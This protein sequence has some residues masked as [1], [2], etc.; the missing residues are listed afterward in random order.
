MVALAGREASNREQATQFD[1][2]RQLAVLLIGGADRGGG[3][4]GDDE[5]EGSMVTHGV[6]G[7]PNRAGP[8]R[9]AM[10]T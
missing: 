4:L 6:A 9:R 10:L 3:F 7:K 1:G 5:H 2:G 8:T